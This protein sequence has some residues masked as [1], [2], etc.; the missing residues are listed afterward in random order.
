VLGIFE[1]VLADI[2]KCEHPAVRAMSQKF[3]SWERDNYQLTVQE[4]RDCLSE[5]DTS[6]LM[7]GSSLVVDDGRTAE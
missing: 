1:G 3:G 7:T 2:A 6:A 5:S 4:I